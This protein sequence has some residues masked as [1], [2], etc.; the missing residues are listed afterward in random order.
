MGISIFAVVHEFLAQERNV[1]L[2]FSIEFDRVE[3][4]VEQVGNNRIRKGL[5]VHLFAPSAPVSIGI[6]KQWTGR[7]LHK[8]FGILDRIP[9]Y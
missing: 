2:A 3:F 9:F 7:L 1:I 4:V 8:L 6:Y 5:P